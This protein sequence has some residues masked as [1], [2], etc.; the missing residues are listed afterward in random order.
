[1]TADHKYKKIFRQSLL[2][3]TGYGIRFLLRMVKTIIISRYLGPTY[4]GIFSLIVLFPTLLATIGNMGF[5]QAIVFYIA[6]KG[7]ELPKVLGTTIVFVIGCSIFLVCTALVALMFPDLFGETHEQLKV[8]QTAM[9]LAIP[10]LIFHRMGIQTIV[11]KGYVKAFNA[12]GIADSLIPILLFGILLGIGFPPFSAAVVSWFSGLVI[13]AAVPYILMIRKLD[14]PIQ[15]NQNFLKEGIRYG[16][17]SH[18][19]NV[20]IMVLFRIDFLFITNMLGPTELG[21]YAVATAIAE[22]FFILPEAIGI[23]FVPILFGSVRKEGDRMVP[24]VAKTTFFFLAIACCGVLVLGEPFIRLFFG[25][26]FLPAFL[27]L[28]VLLP[29]IVGMSLFPIFK[30][31]LFS[32]E[33]QGTVSK[34][35]LFALLLNIIL[36]PILIRTMG[37]SGAAVSSSIAYCFLLVI[38]FSAHARLSGN[39][40]FKTFFFTKEELSTI[41]RLAVKRTEKKK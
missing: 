9:L 17:T 19:A 3:F 11:A 24:L 8:F 4:R 34:Y 5:G 10:L 32:R 12:I 25:K 28:V 30:A 31:D 1:M 29:G 2:T 21:Y 37:I 35:A 33:L 39:T 6:K 23:P 7:Y 40:I 41:F 38:T 14:S 27:P 18:L 22:I 36:N 16:F 15:F 20:F 13:V 26:V